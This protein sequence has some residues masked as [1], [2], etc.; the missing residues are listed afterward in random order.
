[1]EVQW[2]GLGAQQK[3]VIG[4]RLPGE[5][6]QRLERRRRKPPDLQAV[7][8]R[9]VG[10][11][12]AQHSRVGDDGNAAAGGQRLGGQHLGDIEQLGESVHPNHAGLPEEGVHCA[13][14]IRG[15]G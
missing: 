6:L 15:L 12:P 7:G 8:D 3:R 13:F 2:A 5:G 4:G 1:M 9:G 10:G 14:R 11:E